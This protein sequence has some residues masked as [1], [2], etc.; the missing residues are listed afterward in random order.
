MSIFLSFRCKHLKSHLHKLHMIVLQMQPILIVRC[1]DTSVSLLSVK[2]YHLCPSRK[3]KEKL[4]APVISFLFLH[5]LVHTFLFYGWNTI[6]WHRQI[7]YKIKYFYVLV[8]CVHIVVQRLS[9]ESNRSC[10]AN[11]LELFRNHREHRPFVC[12]QPSGQ[13]FS[14]VWSVFP[15]EPM[16][17]LFFISLILNQ[18]LLILENIFLFQTSHMDE[19]IFFPFRMIKFSS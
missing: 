18:P 19:T 17:I 8:L 2:S 15:A 6:P 5:L 14:L 4:S 1:A 9:E 13:W 3:M 7:T 11:S 12:Q 16:Y 10:S